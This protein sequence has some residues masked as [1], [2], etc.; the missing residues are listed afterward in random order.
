[1][2]KRFGQEFNEAEDL[3]NQFREAVAK[4]EKQVTDCG[5]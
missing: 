2:D 5:Y 1:M 4:I 3:L